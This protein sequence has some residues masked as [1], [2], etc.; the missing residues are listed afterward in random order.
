MSAVFTYDPRNLAVVIVPATSGAAA[1]TISGFA[2]DDVIEVERDM[3]AWSKKVG[4]DGQVTRARQGDLSG[5]ITLHLM[6]SSSSND[7]L[8][9]LVAADEATPPAGA[10]GITFKDPSGTSVFRATG[11]V[12]KPAK[13]SYK[14][15]T[16]TREWVIDCATMDAAGGNYVVGG[17]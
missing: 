11:W 10:F 7:D 14:K 9:A 13:G 6:Q 16:D 2:D 15:D 1:L 5:K 8:M 3:D 12:K 4:V 17:N